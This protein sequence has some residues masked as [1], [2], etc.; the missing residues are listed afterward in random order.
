[1]NFDVETLD[2]VAKIMER[3]AILHLEIEDKDFELEIDREPYL[4]VTR[5]AEQAD[6]QECEEEEE[7][8]EEEPAEAPTPEPPTTEPPAAESATAEICAALDGASP[9]TT[10]DIR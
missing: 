6:E 3:Y 7:E 2:T 1:M 4:A 5:P 8:E 10:V 9:S